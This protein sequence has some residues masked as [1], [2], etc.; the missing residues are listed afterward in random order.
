MRTLLALAFLLLAT[1]ATA[2]TCKPMADLSFPLKATAGSPAVLTTTRYGAGNEKVNRYTLNYAD[3]STILLEQQ[4]C[5]ESNLRLT[6]LSLNEKPTLLELNRL[7]A[8]LATTNVWRS[9]FAGTNASTLLQEELSTP[10]FTS[11]LAKG[12]PFSYGTDERIFAPGATS[13]TSLG[14][15]LGNAATQFRSLLTLTISVRGS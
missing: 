8:V 6:L 11:R 1:T 7:S 14:F 12:T 9:A 2:Q 13:H 5:T 4:D 10:D 15:T 3:G